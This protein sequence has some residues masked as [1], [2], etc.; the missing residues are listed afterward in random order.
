MGLEKIAEYKKKLG[1]T[2]E[3]LSE[4]SGVPLGTLNKILSGAT[5]DPKLETLKSI[6]HVLGLTLDDFDDKAKKVVPEPTYADVERL[7]ARN[8]K[9]MSVEQK[10]RLIKLLSEINDED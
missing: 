6:A 2:S 10:M 7:V 1:M 5:K 8:G 9:Q 3:E 4:K